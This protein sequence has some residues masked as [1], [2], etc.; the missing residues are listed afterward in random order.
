M[1]VTLGNRSTIP[2]PRRGSGVFERARTVTEPALRAAVDSLPPTTRRAVGYHFGWW[3]S[4]GQD[5]SGTPGKAFRPALVLLAAEAVGGT[6]V[7][8]AA[9]AAVPAAIPAAV[10]VELVHHFAQL[11]EKNTTVSRRFG[12]G[13]AVLAGDALLA[14]AFDVLATTAHPR[15]AAATHT[16]GA[17]VAQLVEGQADDRREDVRLDECFRMARRRTGALLECSAGLGGLFGGGT[18]AQV[19]ALRAFG[20]ELGLA[21]QLTDDRR[22][23]W[24][25]GH[26]DLRHRERSLPVVA[27]LASKSATAERIADAYKTKHD[28]C[29]VEAHELADALDADGWREWC[30]TESERHLRAALDQ[31]E[32]GITAERRQDLRAIARLVGDRDR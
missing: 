9:V 20:A 17:T 22:G 15:A 11:R 31:L 14:L 30:V 21:I 2:A 3:D 4:T 26:P 16:L 29:N 13:A 23:I 12:T 25:T 19:A 1:T 32:P 7:G 24:G 10:A 6:P 28:L 8:M 18:P 5:R 27:A